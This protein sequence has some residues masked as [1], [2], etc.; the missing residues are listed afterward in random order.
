MSKLRVSEHLSLP[1]DA[2]TETFSFLAKRGA[3]KT[4]SAS[5][6]AEE[7]LKA[8][9]QIVAL[10]PTGAW[11]GLRSGFPIMVAGGEHADIPLEEHSGEILASAIV[12]N[13]LSAILDVSL[14][15]K[16]QTVRFMVSFAETLYRLNREPMHLFVDE[17]DQFA[18]QGRYSGGGEENRMLGAM[19]DIVRRG[20]KRGIG[21]SLIT[22]RPA[23]L[24]KSVL[25]QC[26]SL[27]VFRLGHPRDI[28][29]VMEWVHVHA[30]E[31]QAQ[32]MVDSLPTLGIG[33]C[34]FW[35]PGWLGA[36]KRVQ[37]RQRET[38]DSSATP[39]PGQTIRAPKSMKEIDLAALGDKIKAT[40]TK[41]KENDPAELKRQIAELRRQL[42][43]RPTETKVEKVVEH[44][45]V[46][47]LKNGQLDKALSLVERLEGA[48]AKVG[49][50]AGPIK[51]AIGRASTPAAQ[52]RPAIDWAAAKSRQPA[53]PGTVLPA[54]PLAQEVTAQQE[55]GLSNTSRRILDTIL[56]LNYRG[57]DA[58]RES[59]A[60][61]LCLHPN[62]GRYGRDLA[63]LRSGGY[64]NGFDLTGTGHGEA[65]EPVITGIEGVV[66]S[67][68]DATARRMFETI[69]RENRPLT[70]EELAGILGLHPN[71]GRYG[72][73]LAWLRTMGVIS[74]RGDIFVTEGA[75]R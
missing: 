38:F 21:C 65:K 29:A 60:R 42:Q 30:E 64:L 57:I 44:V 45:E 32:Q 59:V 66:Q 18:P 5:V 55:G 27:F 61:W 26:G 23:V 25:T 14:M 15:R 73:D 3:G 11:F 10:D 28:D 51:D 9:Q 46:P 43:S 2:V 22:Q 31:D 41:A 68:K 53:A 74:E 6:M 7:M 70:R 16:G 62:G 67:I 4:Y 47:V 39:K 52:A 40:A 72:R 13:R 8:G 12:E 71:G 56:M 24:N 58:N 17:A 54:A 69:A 33:E 75:K 35:S 20:R 36:M 37:I 19:E 50:V 48:I 63:A 34:W 1:I 49:E